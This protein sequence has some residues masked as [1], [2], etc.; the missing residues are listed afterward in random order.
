MVPPCFNLRDFSL[1]N[2]FTREY[3][4]SLDLRTSS[5]AFYHLVLGSFKKFNL[6]EDEITDSITDTSY[7]IGVNKL[8]GHDR[9]IDAISFHT[10]GGIKI[11]NLFNFKYR[12]SFETCERFYAASEID[13]IL[14]F[15]NALFQKDKSFFNDA[16]I[17]LKD[18]INEIWSILSSTSEYKI[19]F[20]FC[21]NGS[22][23]IEESENKRVK[24]ELMK[25]KIPLDYILGSDIVNILNERDKVKLNAKIKF[26]GKEYFD[27]S[28]GDIRAV[29]VNI[30]ARDM[31]RIVLDD[32]E[33]RNNA[34][35]ENY[36]ELKGVEVLNDAFED[37]VRIYQQQR[38]KINKNIK[39][40]A[41][42]ESKNT[43]FFYFNNGITMTCDKVK[44]TPGLNSP[45]AIIENLQVVNGCQTIYSLYDAFQEDSS[46]FE[47]TNI[48]CKIY[49]TSNKPLSMNIAEFTNSQ[50][51][52]N[53]RDIRSVDYAQITLETELLK[54]GYFYER[55]KGMYKGKPTEKRIDAER[56]GQLLLSF[57]NKMP[58]EA[59]NKKTIIFD[60][61][62]NK[63][64]N[65]GINAEYI[66]LVNWLYRQIELKKNVWKNE[67]IKE[68]SKDFQLE[69]FILHSSFYIL[70]LLSLKSNLNSVKL[71][72]ENREVI[73]SYYD[74]SYD[75]IKSIV[76]NKLSEENYSHGVLF[77]NSRLK[78]I[79][80]K[81]LM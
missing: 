66:L 2:T 9:G 29:V 4:D 39:K 72:F 5:D 63:V 31:I 51:P 34:A 28:D 30:D 8:G 77:K 38:G 67:A 61:Y 47:N 53:N 62:Y 52:V 19:R 50:N 17:V 24:K 79:L 44:Y 26:I 78:E 40:T 27:K 32:E 70:Y 21:T 16:N 22:K 36:E 12:E 20:Y 65:E 58:A 64:F 49:E 68:D 73:F 59:K 56:T 76:E 71:S 75:I 74:E 69:S 60:T 55:K 45:I 33:I 23:G 15:F 80:V 1:I 14:S 81:K 18:K 43:R 48:L 11:I 3:I 54:K 35:I 57:F 6:S 37:N 42:D 10:E 46:K 7:N 13:K 25:W 41:L